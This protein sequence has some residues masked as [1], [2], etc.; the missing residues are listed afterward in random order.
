M[1]QTRG[2]LVATVLVGIGAL[3]PLAAQAQTKLSVTGP[4][5]HS[6]PIAIS[7]LKD[8]SQNGAGAKLAGEFA[9]IL[10][11][12][13]ELAGLF[14]IIDRQA[15][16]EQ[17]ET[18]GITAEQ[19]N[20][21]NWSVIG[22]LA[23]V[24]GSLQISGDELTV[25]VRLFDVFQQRQLA[26]RRYRYSPPQI[27]RIANRFADEIM[28]VFTNERGPFDSRI[29]FVSTRGGR[30]KNIYVMSPDGGDLLQVTSGKT[31]DLSPSWSPDARSLLYTSYKKGNP[32]L[33][34]LDLIGVR[35]VRLSAEKGLNLGGKWSPDGSRLAVALED[36]GNSDI[37]L[38]DREGRLIRRLTEHWAIDVSPSWSPDGQRLA[39]CSNRSGT[40]HIYVMHADG[41]GVT[42]ISH[43]GN[44]NTSPAWSPKGDRIAYVGRSGRFNIFT[45][46]T[47]GSGTKQ[48]TNGEG[49]N[50]D[51][52]WAPDGRYL[53]FSSTRGGASLLYVTDQ[54][55]TSQVPLTRGG[56][57]DTSASW[58][59]WL[60]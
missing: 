33:Y 18:S 57:D 8:L 7:P 53:V 30:F 1:T 32:D 23:L 43:E 25:E 5:S 59:R 58:S 45:V 60:E 46:K 21:A 56:G 6:Y 20:F 11:R 54:N 49:N 22:A 52:S 31:I 41:S 28:E 37:F 47:D 26:G 44:Y 29:A 40:P 48:I 27:R 19:I 36:Q 38:L 13:L 35:E 24:K 9:D 34:L 2:W 14:R 51:P 50:E 3:A 42:R 55:G 12:D 15:Y 10:S 39:F 16:I 17:P 4:G